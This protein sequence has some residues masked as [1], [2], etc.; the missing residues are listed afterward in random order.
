MKLKIED[1]IEDLRLTWRWAGIPTQSP[2]PSDRYAATNA[3]F[4]LVAA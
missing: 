2:P 1:C 3:N 4:V